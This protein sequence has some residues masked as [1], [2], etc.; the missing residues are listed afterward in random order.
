MSEVHVTFVP[1]NISSRANYDPLN[2]F[3]VLFGIVMLR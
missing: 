3:G 2:L 1:N